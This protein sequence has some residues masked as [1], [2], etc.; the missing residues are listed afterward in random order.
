MIQLADTGRK[1]RRG[2]LAALGLGGAATAFAV[3]SRPA[4]AQE[5]PTTE[6]PTPA[7]MAAESAPPPAGIQPEDRPLVDAA[8]VLELTAAAAYAIAGA[9]A[10][11]LGLDASTTTLM[12]TLGAHHQAYAEALSAAYGP[13]A[14]KNANTALLEKLGG[15]AF[16]S[17]SAAD[18]MRAAHDLEH[19]AADTHLSLLGLVL[20]TDIASLIASI[21][22]TEYRHAATLSALLGTAAA[23][24]EAA[25]EDGE[26]ALSLDMITGGN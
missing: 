5:S 3:S 10:S 18:V 25:I 8:K 23:T 6:A 9:R 2:I 21:Q 4:Q 11:Q 1:S 20:S 16:A 22:V 14:S 7:L 26:D 12:A 17:G 13:G 24:D 19:A 15:A